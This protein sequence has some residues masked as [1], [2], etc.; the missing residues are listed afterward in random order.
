MELFRY[1]SVPITRPF[2]NLLKL[3]VKNKDLIKPKLSS[4]LLKFGR[5]FFVNTTEIQLKIGIEVI[6]KD[7]NIDNHLRGIAHNFKL[8][9]DN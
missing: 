6:V 7:R 1:F 5:Q 9:A 2:G 3:F 4:M 8:Q